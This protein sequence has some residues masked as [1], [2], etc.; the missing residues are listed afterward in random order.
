MENKDGLLCFSEDEQRYAGIAAA[1]DEANAPRIYTRVSEALG[2]QKALLERLS[3][4]DDDEI[5]RSERS[6]IPS[7]TEKVRVLENLDKQLGGLSL[8][9]QVEQYLRDK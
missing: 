4:A 3:Y 9:R 5:T 8:S 1:T 2:H 6:E 7:I